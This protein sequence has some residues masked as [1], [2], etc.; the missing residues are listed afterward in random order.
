MR[1]VVVGVITFVGGL[2]CEVLGCDGE[3]GSL[4]LSVE[5]TGL[6]DA[7]LGLAR[8]SLGSN[9]GR[10]VVQ[11]LR[12]DHGVHRVARAVALAFAVYQLRPQQSDHSKAAIR[13]RFLHQRHDQEQH[14]QESLDDISQCSAPITMRITVR[15]D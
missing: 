13:E 14:G 15:V 5:S 8:D 12:A 1:V 10:R 2:I 6:S 9:E 11:H 4:D 3:D 7:W